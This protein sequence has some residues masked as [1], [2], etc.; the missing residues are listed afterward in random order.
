MELLNFWIQLIHQADIP[1]THV[2][3]KNHLLFIKEKKKEARQ[4]LKEIV[5]CKRK[6]AIFNEWLSGHKE[7][8]SRMVQCFPEDNSHA[9]C[10][11]S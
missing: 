3:L 2:E 11:V 10:K 6:Q 1:W 4:G 5:D 8:F 7:S 9:E